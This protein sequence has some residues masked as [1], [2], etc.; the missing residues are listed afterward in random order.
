[1][2]TDTDLKYAE[3]ELLQEHQQREKILNEE[4]KI[5]KKTVPLL[6]D[7]VHTHAL[8]FPALSVQWLPSYTVS[9]N[10]N[11]VS[12]QFVYGTNTSSLSQDYL[13]LAQLEVPST[14]APDFS[15]FATSQSVPI[16]LSNAEGNSFRVLSLW[17]HPGEINRVLVAPGGDRVVTFDNAGVIHL[18]DLK[19]AAAPVDYAYHKSEGYALEWLTADRY[20]SGANDAQIALW[21]VSKPSTPIQLFKS[22]AAA[23][24][25]LALNRGSSSLFGSV[26]D[27]YSTQ[28]HDIRASGDGPAI[29]VANSHIQNA[30]AFHPDVATLYATAGKD[31]TVNLYDLRSPSQPFRQLFGHNDSVIGVSWDPENPTGLSSWGLDKRVIT[32]TLDNL[33]DEF[34]Y[35]TSD[36]NSD[37][38]KRRLNKSSDDPCLYF[39]HGGH[40]NRINDVSLHPRIKNLFVTVGDDSLMEIWRPKTVVLEDEPEDEEAENEEEKAQQ[41]DTEKDDEKEDNNGENAPEDDDEMRDD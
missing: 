14:F 26:S 7:T 4:F 40:T 39:V 8:D 34:V 27:D 13:K 33:E 5:W 37:G 31:N 17:K 3:R 21:D 12:V 41:K 16:P 20:L 10:K 19:S 35:P 15:T 23:I 25:N 28:I 11:S 1:M 24:N 30:I 6:Y 2:T 38:P 29:K 22:H 9:E 32:W 18:F 36:S